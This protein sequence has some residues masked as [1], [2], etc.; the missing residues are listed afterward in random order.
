VYIKTGQHKVFLAD[1]G[2]NLGTA[3]IH[4]SNDNRLF[5]TRV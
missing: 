4:S 2:S 1:L 3:A 5:N